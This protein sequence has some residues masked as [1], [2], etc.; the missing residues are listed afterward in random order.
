MVGDVKVLVVTSKALENKVRELVKGK[1]DVIGIDAKVMALLTPKALAALLKREASRRGVNLNEYDIILTSA[2]I[3][4]DLK[5]IWEEVGPIYKGTKDLSTLPL[6][7]DHLNEIELRSDK[8]VDEELERYLLDSFLKELSFEYEYA[9]D[10]GVRIPYSPPPFVIFAEVLNEDQVERAL[11]YADLLVYGSVSPK[12]DL[13]KLRS[14]MK[15]YDRLPWGIDS[16]HREE[17]KEA[18]KLGA[19]VVMSITPK[20]V[21]KI[22]EREAVY[23]MIPDDFR[24]R[25]ESLLKGA[26]RAKRFGVK[27]ILDPVLSP[28]PNTLNSLLEYKKLKN[29]KMPK[30]FGI[31]NVTELLDADSIGVNLLLTQLAMEVKASVLLT[32]EASNKCKGSYAEVKLASMMVSVAKIRGSQ[33]KNLGLDMLFLKEK[34]MEREEEKVEGE[35]VNAKDYEFPLKEGYFRIWV[36]DKIYAKYHG[37]K[38]VTIVGERGYEIGKTAI[39]LGLVKDPSHALYLGKEL[40]KAELALRLEKSYIQEKDLKLESPRE[41]ALKVLRALREVPRRSEP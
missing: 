31:S 21:E 15:R 22:E 36:K 2:M 23:V 4:G 27:V 25:A 8:G 30:M 9:Y 39:A 40:Y 32:I 18:L 38:K 13:E 34:K 5:E 37:K 33:I 26:E 24:N 7:L 41:R 17:V 19:K 35:L 20:E 28:F 6:L 11:D 12:P 14:L 1:A 10:V 3:M 16:P 29:V